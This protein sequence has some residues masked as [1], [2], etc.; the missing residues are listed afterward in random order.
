M[1]EAVKQLSL[2]IGQLSHG[3]LDVDD[4]PAANTLAAFSVRCDIPHKP[5]TIS[6]AGVLAC[7]DLL[8]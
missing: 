3:T 6:T 2:V 8:H 7:H 5:P 4:L 1:K